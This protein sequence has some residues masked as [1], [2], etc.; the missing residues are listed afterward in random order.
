LWCAGFLLLFIGRF[1]LGVFRI[2]PKESTTL[3]TTGL[4]AL[5][6]NPMYLGVY[7]T[8]LGSTLYTLNP[9]VLLIG[10]YIVAM[11]HR[12]VLA[13]EGFLKEAFGSEY[14]DYCRRVRRF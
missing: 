11:H 9:V 5:S 2:G 10:I 13:E 6:R 8:L 1:G 14:A 4:F 3:R 7:S 12:I